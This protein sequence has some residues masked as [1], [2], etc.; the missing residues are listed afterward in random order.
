MRDLLDGLPSEAIRNLR[1]DER[2]LVRTAQILAEGPVAQRAV[3]NDANAEYPEHLLEPFW[4]AGLM[5]MQAPTE[6]GGG[7]AS[8]TAQ[9]LVIEAVA[10]VCA[11]SAEILDAQG[12]AML[13]LMSSTDGDWARALFQQIRDRRWLLA[14]AL[15]EPDAGSD[16]GALST[17]AT[18][19]GEIWTLNGTKVFC[20]N[21][22]GR[23]DLHFV[24][25]RTGGTDRGRG[26][27]AFA[28]NTDTDGFEISSRNRMM[29]L[30]GSF[31][32]TI[33]LANVEV[34]NSRLLP[35]ENEG[36]RLATRALIANRVYVAAISVGLASAAL[37]YAIQY[38][39]NQ[40]Q[41]GKRINFQAVQLMLADSA[42]AT[43]RARLYLYRTTESFR[44]LSV[45]DDE[46]ELN[47]RA[48]IAKTFASDTAM[49][50]TTD[51][52]QVLG[53]QGYLQIHPVE[54]MM[55]DAKAFQILDGTNQI[56][57]LIIN[58]Q[59]TSGRDSRR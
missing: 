48:S 47:K 38:L 50:V 58:K 37:D 53:E 1:K 41:F 34:P 9:A 15:T 5:T 2:D 28:V 21:G 40:R 46:G 52:V 8:L 54:R 42:I 17:K 25:A 56:H 14:F 12:A 36:Y 23:A 33:H 6:W 45:V 29:G 51:A 27:S 3:L 20:T 59:L 19:R 35:P 39:R 10:R 43:E 44:Q 13:T 32:T 11:S 57:R 26:I 30:R 22:G 16:A 55:R 18:R 31:T 7:G 49:Q 24:Y 4:D